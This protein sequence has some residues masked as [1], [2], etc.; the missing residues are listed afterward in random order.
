MTLRRDFTFSGR[1]RRGEFWVRW[2][3]VAIAALLLM[4]PALG[5]VLTADPI[6]SWPL[7]WLLLVGLVANVYWFSVMIRRWHDRGKSAWWV[8]I[9]FIPYV[10]SLWVLIELGFLRGDPG[11]N[12]YGDPSP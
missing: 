2:I 7:F 10:G 8:L 1:L 9:W 6:P 5:I 3:V 4:L 11:P 12:R